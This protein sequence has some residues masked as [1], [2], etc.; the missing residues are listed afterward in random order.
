[1]QTIKRGD[2]WWVAFDPSLGQEI[3]KTRPAIVIS[4]NASNRVLERFQV[5]PV[6]SNIKK[7]YPSQA[8][9][10]I[11]DKQ[12]KALAD[13]LTTAAR[14]RFISYIG[15]ISEEDMEAVELAVGIQLGIS[16]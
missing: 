2:I 3:Q 1:M 5:L 14:E 6:T 10:H 13:Q 7:I 16:L 11:N 8:L 15:S 9:I 4:C 12:S